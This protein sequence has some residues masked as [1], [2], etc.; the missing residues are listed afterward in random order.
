M[1]EERA[2]AFQCGSDWLY[3]VASLP[4]EPSVRGVLIVV[5]GPQYRAGSHRQFTLLARSL[6]GAGIPAMRFDY[7]GMGDSEGAMRG[8]DEVNKDI[9]AAIDRFFEEAPG[10]SEVLLWG[11]CD[12][13]SAAAMYA[14]RDA[15]VAGLALLNPWVRTE[16]GA[17]RATIKHY[18]GARLLQREFWNKLLAGRFDA[19]GAIRSFAGLLRSSRRHQES[20]DLPDRMHNALSTFRGR[21]L[22]MLS[23]ADLTA[24]EFSDLSNQAKWKGLLAAKRFE[25]HTLPK[26]D[27]TCSRREWHEQL[28]AWTMAWAR[29]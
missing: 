27:H 2:L 15:R 13:A 17:A 1:P 18:Y 28:A 7:R 14:P 4:P 26:A 11:L 22:L 19:R 6:A 8:F 12:G 9:R 29:A 20:Q 16:E 3:G 24:Q 21:V 5:G 25:R 10:M 23:G